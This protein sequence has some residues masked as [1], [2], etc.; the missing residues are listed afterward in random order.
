MIESKIPH[1]N[2]SFQT[3]HDHFNEYFHIYLSQNFTLTFI[4]QGSDILLIIKSSNSCNYRHNN[5][6]HVTLTHSVPFQLKM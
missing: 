3:K 5:I 2:Y 4:S 1:I 6:P